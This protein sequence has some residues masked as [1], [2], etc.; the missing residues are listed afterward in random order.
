MNKWQITAR[1]RFEPVIVIT[2]GITVLNFTAI[3]TE[4]T[5]DRQGRPG[6]PLVTWISCSWPNPPQEAIDTFRQDT[7]VLLIGSAY[8]RSY[9]RRDGSTGKDLGM[10]IEQGEFR[11]QIGSKRLKPLRVIDTEPLPS[12]PDKGDTSPEN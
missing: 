11:A 10:N 4:P 1:I 7:E 3:N 5:M 9:P 2:S 6:P 12:D 8:L